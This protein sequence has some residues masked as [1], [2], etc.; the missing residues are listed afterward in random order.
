MHEITVSEVVYNRKL[1][2]AKKKKKKETEGEE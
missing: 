2:L 1:A